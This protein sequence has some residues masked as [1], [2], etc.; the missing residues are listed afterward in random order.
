MLD[1]R[2]ASLPDEGERVA[3]AAPSG[4]LVDHED[5]HIRSAAVAHMIDEGDLLA[6]ERIVAA[7]AIQVEPRHGFLP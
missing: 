4:P 6:D 7:A 1:V 5:V 2:E 3:A